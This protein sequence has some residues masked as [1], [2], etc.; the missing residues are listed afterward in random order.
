MGFKVRLTDPLVYWEPDLDP[1]TIHTNILELL[2]IIINILLAV[3]CM[4]YLTPPPSGW[5]LDARADN[6]SA[7][8]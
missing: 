4:N 6:T 2:A 3:Y 7:L 1:N 5:V 8:A